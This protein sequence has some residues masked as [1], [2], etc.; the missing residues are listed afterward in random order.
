ME[1][2]LEEIMN[3]YNITIHNIIKATPLEVFGVR[4]NNLL[5]R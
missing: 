4:I 3:E 2:A 1:E 5:K